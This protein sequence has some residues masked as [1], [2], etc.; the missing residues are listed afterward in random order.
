MGSVSSDGATTGPSGRPSQVM[1]NDL[2]KDGRMG[3][4]TI[5]AHR[6]RLTMGW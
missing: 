6:I 4:T 3:R 5:T 1:S 2:M